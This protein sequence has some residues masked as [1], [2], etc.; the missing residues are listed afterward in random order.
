MDLTNEA[1]VAVLGD[2]EL[3]DSSVRERLPAPIASLYSYLRTERQRPESLRLAV[4]VS[5][6]LGSRQR[7]LSLV[8][9][10]F[11]VWLLDDPYD[12]VSRFASGDT[13]VAVRRVTALYER[14]C[15]GTAVSP[16][17]WAQAKRAAERATPERGLEWAARTASAAAGAAVAAA[18]ATAAREAAEG[19]AWAARQAAAGAAVEAEG[20]LRAASREERDRQA[21]RLLA[22]IQEAPW[23]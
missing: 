18:G 15:S 10:R 14:L 21:S 12:G 2:Q 19:A 7:D 20:S 11:A 8:W 5:K 1:V 6:A 9:P 16:D 17:E 13:L 23:K 3:D 22:L 4:H